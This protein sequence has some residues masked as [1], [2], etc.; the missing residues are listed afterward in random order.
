MVASE[1][2]VTD[3]Q[4]RL[5][6]AALGAVLVL[7]GCVSAPPGPVAVVSPEGDP[8]PRPG[9]FCGPEATVAAELVARGFRAYDAEDLGAGI[10]G[11]TVANPE[12]GEWMI[13]GTNGMTACI[14][15]T[16]T[17]E[18]MPEF[19]AALVDGEAV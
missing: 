4:A 13:V 6:C 19:L 18:D 5:F 16:G 2:G 9:V 10:L 12:T 1:K 7:G 3:M 15:R 8:T 17:R 14:T 11:M